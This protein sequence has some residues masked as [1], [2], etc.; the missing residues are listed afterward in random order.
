MATRLSGPNK[1]DM[2]Q[3]GELRVKLLGTTA[4]MARIAYMDDMGNTMGDFIFHAWSERSWELLNELAQSVEDDYARR[5]LKEPTDG[6]DEYLPED[7]FGDSS[8]RL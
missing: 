3:V 8:L 4:G 1:I 7:D 5:L 2:I 6:Q